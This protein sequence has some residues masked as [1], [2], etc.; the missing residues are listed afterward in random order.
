MAKTVIHQTP[1]RRTLLRGA[2]VDADCFVDR[3]SV[4]KE[5]I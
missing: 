1:H 4:R 3:I 5:Q 2:G